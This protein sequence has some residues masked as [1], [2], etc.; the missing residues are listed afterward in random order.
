MVEMLPW[1]H[2]HQVPSEQLYQGK[3]KRIIADRY[4]VVRQGY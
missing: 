1:V 2:E 4:Y 3:I